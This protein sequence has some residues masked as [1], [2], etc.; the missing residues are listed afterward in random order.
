M[1]SGVY[2]RIGFILISML[3]VPMTARELSAQTPIDPEEQYRVDYERL[4]TITAIPQL[5]SRGN[6]LYQFM[7]ER[8]DSKLTDYAQ[9]VFYQT[10]DTLLKQGNDTAVLGLSER[11]VKLRPRLGEAYCFY[12]IALKNKKRYPEAIDALAKSYVLKN[13]KLAA[14]AKEV[15]DLVYKGINKGSLAGQDD[16]IK[17]AQQEVK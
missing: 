17:K 5:D 15:L 8:P 11:M 13:N 14:K 7:K 2:R 16:L 9:S 4:Q 10:L 12:G 6:G 1:P 3:L